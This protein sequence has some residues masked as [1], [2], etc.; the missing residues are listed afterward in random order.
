MEMKITGCVYTKNN[1]NV[2]VGALTSLRFVDELI[3]LDSGSEDKTV[4]IGTALV[5]RVEHRSWT[6]FCDQLNHISTLATHEWVLV[7]DADERISEEGALEIKKVLENPTAVCYRLPRLTKY[8]GSWLRHGEFYPDYT[9][10]LYK[11]GSGH[12]EGEP[13]AQYLPE[14]TVEDLKI[15]M[16]HYMLKNL[17]QQLETMDRYSLE[18]AKALVNS[19]KKSARLAA[20]IH[21]IQRFVKGYVFKGGFL[22]GWAG[23][24]AASTASFHVFF[25]YVRVEEEAQFKE[26]QDAQTP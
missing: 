5:D 13:H 16:R 21:S 18:H 19:G 15:P 14:G 24:V 10:R 11:K 4:E 3:L 7:L 9:I 20:L 25:K 1:E 23:F 6:G 2:I 26:G 22:D 17:G 8:L 12:Y